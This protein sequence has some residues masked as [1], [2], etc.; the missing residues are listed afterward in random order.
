[1]ELRQASLV[2]FQKS[3]D[4]TVMYLTECTSR[5]LLK[6][7]SGEDSF[8]NLMHY[9]IVSLANLIM[10]S[11]ICMK[12]EDIPFTNLNHL[13]TDLDDFGSLSIQKD[14]DEQN[15]ITDLSH[16]VS[17]ENVSVL[18]NTRLTE[19]RVHFNNLVDY[20]INRVVEIFRRTNK[21]RI[22]VPDIHV[23]ISE[24]SYFTPQE[25]LNATGGHFFDVTTLKRTSDVRIVNKHNVWEL[26][27]GFGL[28]L[29]NVFYE[30]YM[31][32]DGYLSV[33]G[34]IWVNIQGVA[35]RTKIIINCSHKPGGV[36]LQEL[37][38]PELGDISVSITGLYFNSIASYLV[39]YIVNTWRNEI[40]ALV[41]EKVKEVIQHQIDQLSCRL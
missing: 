25:S 23:P 7:I 9:E 37:G 12:M 14:V 8:T 35:F 17:D 1:M 3:D 19:H 11:E 32:F 34:S 10:T 22:P 16:L 41:L 40:A 29:A 6:E 5:L 33:S 28:S 38:L 15:Q 20:L 31:L 2:R 24:G 18:P 4:E 36:V 39:S 26:S 21:G 27:C 30:H 13:R